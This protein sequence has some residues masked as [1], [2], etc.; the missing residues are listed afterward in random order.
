[1]GRRVWISELDLVHDHYCDYAGCPG[2]V[3]FAQI[4]DSPFV[5]DPSACVYA[6]A[7]NYA[8]LTIK[9]GCRAF[10]LEGPYIP[11]DVENMLRPGTDD[12]TRM[13]NN[14]LDDL[15]KKW[16]RELTS[17][18]DCVTGMFIK[19]EATEDDP[20]KKRVIKHFSAPEGSCCNAFVPDVETTMMSVRCSLPYLK[21][22][23]SQTK[24][25]VK[26]AF[27]R[28]PLHP[29]SAVRCN[30]A[31]VDE[32]T[33]VRRYF[34]DLRLNWGLKCAMLIFQRFTQ[35]VRL[36]VLRRGHEAV[37]LYVDDFDG[38]EPS[39]ERN[40]ILHKLICSLLLSL[41]LPY[42][43]APDKLIVPSYCITFLGVLSDTDTDGEGRV[44]LRITPA[45]HKK[46]LRLMKEV[47]SKHRRK[48]G[49]VTKGEL[50]SLAGFLVYIFR[51]LPM[52]RGATIARS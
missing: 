35:L 48:P 46:M 44:T 47:L 30:Y 26:G 36:M 37:L 3:R 25:D 18:P 12:E 2:V 13:K 17:K 41:G 38:L 24:I 51:R 43:E 23:T 11:F 7:C 6:N 22:R 14:I 21:A 16:L 1:L 5:V 31:I 4:T 34:M 33:K 27:R 42:A 39:H 15:N 49:S 9:F 50:E 20:D 10:G 19:D 52:V 28:I 32:E 29:T 8:L 40:W 45:K